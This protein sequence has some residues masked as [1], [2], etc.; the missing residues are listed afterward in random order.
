[1][2]LAV[3]QPSIDTVNKT[4]AILL[5][6]AIPL[7]TTLTQVLMGLLLLVWIL[8]GNLKEKCRLVFEH[9]VSR[10]ACFLFFI[11]LIGSTYSIA[12][13]REI[14]AQL[15]KMSKLLYFACLIPIFSDQKLRKTAVWTFILA[16]MI[17]LIL[18]L[19]RVYGQLFIPT[20]YPDA[21]IFKNHIDTN[22]MMS[23][24]AFF[25][26][27]ECVT[28][29]QQK[30]K[31]LGVA[32][33][34]A[35]MFTIFYCL[36]MSSGRTGYVVFAVLW[37]IF[38]LQRFSL[39]AGIGSILLLSILLGLIT[40]APLSP[41]F[42][43]RLRARFNAVPVE[44]QLYRQGN[45][46]SVGQ[47]LS[48]LTQSSKLIQQRPLFGWGTGSFKTAY[49]KL[50]LSEPM[51]SSTNPHNEY[52]NILVQWGLLGL[53][54]L[55]LL[56]GTVF[57]ISFKLPTS[58]RY[59]AHGVLAAFMV[60]SLAN[61]LFMDITSGYV[62]VV[63]IAACMAAYSPRQAGLIPLPTRFSASEKSLALQGK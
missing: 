14:L 60:G 63:M 54:G 37:V 55:L 22:F 29:F 3:Y 15:G 13:G 30:A 21:A 2:K 61:S 34:T 16:M 38:Y 62:F 9:P 52:L 36:W 18:A 49:E 47:R 1:M 27:H 44:V 48:Y 40:L 46:T 5:V 12:S 8:T 31:L 19:L 7:S 45:E 35:V 33:L 43:P 6:F 23:L 50:S 42:Q 59:I 20:R 57:K 51:R 17:T 56:L 26:A 10:S 53:T 41:P 39:K 58:E 32:L 4:L 11:L 24:A 25:L 28:A